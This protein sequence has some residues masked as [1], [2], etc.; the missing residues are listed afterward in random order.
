MPDATDGMRTFWDT[1]A[2]TNAPWY[3]DTSISYDDPDMNAF[4]ETGRV[5]AALALDGPVQP[6]ERRLAVEIGPGLGRIVRSL[7]VDQGFENA[8]G[9]DISAEMV[10]QARELVPDPRV[11]FEIG[12]GAGLSAVDDESADLVT[13]FT[14]FQ[15]I[16][17]VAVIEQYLAEAGRV[18][19]P[20][21]VVAFQWNNLPGQRRWAAKREL[22][23]LLQRTGLRPERFRRN[24]P[25][26]LGSRVSLRRIERALGRAGL[27][28]RGT[29]D[30]GTLF[31]W[32]WATK[33]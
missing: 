5:I 4:W 13:S 18:L 31:A 7:V 33:P 1:A 29:R 27:E 32:A 8:V 10:R 6:T 14:V 15:H 2:A 16:P 9:V 19:R 11:R 26:F 12:T 30:T 20:G 23:G 22:L 24:A 3:V 28:L 25:Q 17:K 21:G